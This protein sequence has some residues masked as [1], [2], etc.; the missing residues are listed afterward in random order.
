MLKEILN[1]YFAKI[2]GVMYNIAIIVYELYNRLYTTLVILQ[3][4][5]YNIC[6]V[7]ARDIG[8]DLIKIAPH[9]SMDLAYTGIHCVTHNSFHVY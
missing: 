2:T 5:S 3:N 1:N 9:L 8:A 4:W 6:S 7:K